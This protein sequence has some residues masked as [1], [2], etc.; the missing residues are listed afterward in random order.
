MKSIVILGKPYRVILAQVD[1]GDTKGM[2]DSSAQTI[3]LYKHAT[4]EDMLDTF[5]HEVLH[6]IHR[7]AGIHR[8]VQEE[9]VFTGIL[10][11]VLADTLTR[12]GLM[13]NPFG[14]YYSEV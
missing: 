6:R 4:P 1:G 13:A 5:L 14:G 7:E 10:A 11:T 12:N 9:E 3:T 2:S 8:M